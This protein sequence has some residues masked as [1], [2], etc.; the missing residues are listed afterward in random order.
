V[1]K[2]KN[3]KQYFDINLL[4]SNKSIE[5][6]VS[7]IL[8][9]YEKNFVFFSEELLSTRHNSNLEFQ[10]IHKKIKFNNQAFVTDLENIIKHQ[11]QLENIAINRFKEIELMKKDIFK[12]LYNLESKTNVNLKNEK[13]LIDCQLNYIKTQLND[14]SNSVGNSTEAIFSSLNK[15]ISDNNFNNDFAQKKF[16]EMDKNILLNKTNIKKLEENIYDTVSKM[17]LNEMTQKVM[18]ENM[19]V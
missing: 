16:V 14:M 6:N 19:L 8:K 3:M 18:E 5:R 17:L 2:L 10:N 15:L 7:K 11:V 1:N 13:V 12:E 4:N 9:Q